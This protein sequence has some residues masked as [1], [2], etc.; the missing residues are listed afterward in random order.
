MGRGKYCEL[1]ALAS[2]LQG[3]TELQ[4]CLRRSTRGAQ[5]CSVGFSLVQRHRQNAGKVWETCSMSVVLRSTGDHR[6]LAV[7]VA[8]AP[9]R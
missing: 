9:A 2:R 6:G 4:M 1:V 3:Q 5:G 7:T 8:S